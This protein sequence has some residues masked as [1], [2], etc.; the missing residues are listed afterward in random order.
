MRLIVLL[1]LTSCACPPVDW[2]DSRLR[3][4]TD[5]CVQGGLVGSPMKGDC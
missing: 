1:L 5:G 3:Y 2:S 4:G